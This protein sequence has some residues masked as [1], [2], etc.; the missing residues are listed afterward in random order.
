MKILKAGGDFIYT[1]VNTVGDLPDDPQVKA[2]DYVV[3]YEIPGIGKTQVVGMP[4]KLSE[5]PR[6][7]ARTR[8]RTRRAYG[9][10]ADGAAR[11]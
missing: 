1:V 6:Q 10:G 3:D 5:T 9:G 4:V 8:P 2:N 11:L 7:S